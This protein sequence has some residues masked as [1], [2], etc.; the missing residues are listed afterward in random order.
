MTIA[1]LRARSRSGSGRKMMVRGSLQR[2]MAS[3]FVKEEVGGK[4]P[5]AIKLVQG[6]SQAGVEQVKQHRTAI[7]R[8][9]GSRAEIVT[10]L[11]FSR[12]RCGRASRTKLLEILK[13]RYR[14]ALFCGYFVWCL[15]LTAGRSACEVKV[16]GP[17]PWMDNIG[18][19]QEK[20][21]GPPSPPRSD[22]CSVGP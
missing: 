19:G 4:R 21:G 6:K 2:L 13:Y 15:S 1:K 9:D 20:G 8:R 10:V 12:D 5:V 11:L 14:A 18:R 3:R 16:E 7:A 17:I 22:L